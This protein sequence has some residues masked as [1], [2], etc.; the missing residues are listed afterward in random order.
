MTGYIQFNLRTYLIFV[1]STIYMGFLQFQQFQKYIVKY[2]ID[3]GILYL[4][5]R[6]ASS[7]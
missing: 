2:L 6:P 3:Q 1:C 7:K 5:L 4:T